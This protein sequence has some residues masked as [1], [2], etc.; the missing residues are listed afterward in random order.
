MF[1]VNPGQLVTLPKSKKGEF[2]GINHSRSADF[3]RMGGGKMLE[4]NLGG[5]S[6]TST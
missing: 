2:D 4:K 5:T 1:F 6:D 3:F